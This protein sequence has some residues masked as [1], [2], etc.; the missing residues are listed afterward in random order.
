MA[1]VPLTP[2]YRLRKEPAAHDRLTRDSFLYLHPA[3]PVD[4]FAQCDT[5]SMWLVNDLC[6]IHGPEIKVTASMSCGLYIHGTP[7]TDPRPGDSKKIVTPAESGLVDRQVR[8]ENCRW[9]GPNVYTCGLFLLLNTAHPNV[10]D[11][12]D[13]IDPKGCCNAQQPI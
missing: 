2:M 13:Q 10:F 8:C 9:G 12:D 6:A 3:P 1:V 4:R 11:L 5:C 7:I